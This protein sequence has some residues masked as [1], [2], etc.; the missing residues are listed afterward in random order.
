MAASV[1]HFEDG[2]PDRP[3]PDPGVSPPRHPGCTHREAPAWEPSL[4]LDTPALRSSV[5][6]PVG[7][8]EIV[9]LTHDDHGREFWAALG[10]LL[11]DYEARRERLRMEGPRLVW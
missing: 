1:P 9:H 7:E 10:R 8:D 11:P 2:L 6:A 5:T 4:M 3:G